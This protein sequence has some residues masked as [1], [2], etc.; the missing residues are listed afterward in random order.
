MSTNIENTESIAGQFLNVPDKKTDSEVN[1]TE[2]KPLSRTE[3]L[4][5][6]LKT[7]SEKREKAISAQT[8]AEKKTKAI[9]E[10][11]SKI[12]AELHNNDIRSLDCLCKKNNL[13]IK[14]IVAFLSAVTSKMTL[15]EAAEL[16]EID[17]EYGSDNSE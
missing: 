10:Q 4:S 13:S 17:I 6:K 15:A 12:K 16:L 11:I 1:N 14:S 3:K 8:A 5:E 2:D 9:D 7:L